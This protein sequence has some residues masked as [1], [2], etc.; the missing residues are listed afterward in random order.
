MAEN[1]EDRAVSP[2]VFERQTKVGAH[3]LEDLRVGSLRIAVTHVL[4]Q[5]KCPAKPTVGM[6]WTASTYHFVI[7]HVSETDVHYY[8]RNNY[9]AECQSG[10]L[11][12]LSHER[13][14]TLFGYPHTVSDEFYWRPVGDSSPV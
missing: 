8:V 3:A 7:T 13:I 4:T 5:R 11:L 10:K 2:E 1:Y 6:N 14:H 12:S 9:N